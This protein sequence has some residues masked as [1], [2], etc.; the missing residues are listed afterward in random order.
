M[1]AVY[2]PGEK[3]I[4]TAIV[5]PRVTCDLPLCPIPFSL[6]WN[7]LSDVT[8]A[9]PDFGRPGRVDLLLGVEVFAEVMLHGRRMGPPG[10]PIAFETKFGWVHAGNTDAC[11]PAHHVVTHRASLFTGDDILRKFWELEERPTTESMLSPAE[12]SVVQHFD[13]NHTQCEVFR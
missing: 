11:A 12:R 1:S 5:V 9:D 4:I 6:K 10:S 7:H 2:S 13:T 8:L 3:T